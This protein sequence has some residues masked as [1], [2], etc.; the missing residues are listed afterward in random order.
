[1]KSKE[2]TKFNENKYEIITWGPTDLIY[3]KIKW[4]AQK[5]LNRVYKWKTDVWN[6]SS[7]GRIRY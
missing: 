1:M 5:L 4:Q 7:R 2:K 6:Y 3:K